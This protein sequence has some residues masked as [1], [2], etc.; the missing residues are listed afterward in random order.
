MKKMNFSQ[1][2]GGGESDTNL[3]Q[4]NRNNGMAERKKEKAEASLGTPGG[5]RYGHNKKKATGGETLGF[6]RR[7]GVYL[8][9]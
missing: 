6:S 5:N 8:A 3:L 2:I 7:S 1:M 4:K 9:Y